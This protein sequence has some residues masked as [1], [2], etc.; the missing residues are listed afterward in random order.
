MRFA[1]SYLTIVTLVISVLQIPM[2]STWLNHLMRYIKITISRYSLS[3]LLPFIILLVVGLIIDLL[4]EIL[5]AIIILKAF[6]R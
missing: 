3:W 1:L 4:K 5:K 6:N 2:T